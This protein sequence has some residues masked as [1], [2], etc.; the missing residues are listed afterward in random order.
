MKWLTV[1]VALLA[2]MAGVLV[3]AGVVFA[4]GWI[5]GHDLGAGGVAALPAGDRLRA[6]NDVRATVS[7]RRLR[8]SASARPPTRQAIRPRAQSAALGKRA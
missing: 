6:V 7:H 4:P 1:L 2:I 5:V 8:R 3:V